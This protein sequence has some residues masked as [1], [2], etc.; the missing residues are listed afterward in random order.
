MKILHISDIHYRKNYEVDDKGYKGI[1]YKMQNPLIPLEYCLKRAEKEHP[2]IDCLV[3]SGDLTEDGTP[4]DY[5]ELKTFINNKIG[6]IPIIVTL[7]NHDNKVSFY[8]GWLEKDEGDVPYNAIKNIGDIVFISWDNSKQ[9]NPDGYISEEQMN[10]LKTAFEEN[11]DHHIILLTHH[12]FIEHQASVPSVRHEKE[13]EELLQRYH[14]DCLLCGHTHHK[15]AFVYGD[16]PYY[17]AD[18]MSFYADALMDGSVRFR[19]TYG[20]NY[21]EIIDGIVKEQCAVTL[22]N[23]R[24]LDTMYW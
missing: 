22:N 18:G 3:I 15:F 4:E 9:G 17:T 20:Y 21:Y 24:T 7:G 16:V 2:G 6:D 1:L 10:W 8:K 12:H 5:T 23:G 14:I 11:K 19:E 13:F